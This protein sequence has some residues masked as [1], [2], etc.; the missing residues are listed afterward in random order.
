[1]SKS[2]EVTL[3]IEKVTNYAPRFFVGC[4]PEHKLNHLPDFLHGLWHW[5]IHDPLH[6]SFS[7]PTESPRP[8]LPSDSGFAFPENP[9]IPL[10]RDQ[11]HRFNDHFHDVRHGHVDDLLHDALLVYH[12][13]HLKMLLCRLG[14]WNIDSRQCVT[15]KLF[16][17]F[18]SNQIKD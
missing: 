6:D 2:L 3:F 9:R 18:N 17:A 7:A 5:H 8:H 14:H 13:D 10:L 4:A 15:G 11:D 12:L 1:M 16:F